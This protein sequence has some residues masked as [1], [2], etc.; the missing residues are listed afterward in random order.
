MT[1]KA[2]E[3]TGGC[4]VV[5][6]RAIGTKAFLRVRIDRKRVNKYLETTGTVE[7]LEVIVV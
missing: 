5:R 1:Q 2:Q 6:A 7:R 3:S 4:R